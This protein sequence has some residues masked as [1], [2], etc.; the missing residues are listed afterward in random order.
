MHSERAAQDCTRVCH[1]VEGLAYGGA[2]VL[3]HELAV[4]LRDTPFA[5]LV[6][7]LQ[8]GP[9]G[10]AMARDGITIECLDLPRRAITAGPAFATFVARVVSRLRRVIDTHH[11]GLLHAHLPDPIMW[12]TVAGALEGIPVVGTHHGPA[13]LPMGR[14]ALDPRNALRR[15]LYRASARYSARTIAVSREVHDL[16]CGPFGFDPRTTVLITNG[17]DTAKYGGP[18]DG[19][20]VRRELGLEGRRVLTCIARLA[21][22]KGQAVLIDALTELRSTRPDLAVVIVG[23]GVERPAL[24]ALARARGL[25]RDVLFVGRRADIPDVLD[26]TDVF[27]LPSFGEG[28]PLALLEAMATGIPAVATAIPGN[29]DIISDPSVGVLVPPRDAAALARGLASVLDDPEFARRLGQAG[30]AHVRRHFDL[31]T[32]VEVTAG[33]Y[34]DVL[35]G[36]GGGRRAAA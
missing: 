32:M 25:E 16:L 8:N 5:P 14:G 20:R 28:I 33:V 21:P 36:R 10:E 31:A 35:A 19:A 12:A 34:N 9:V 2:E 29:T 24:E 7:C 23:F 4:R 27:V 15:L 22:I 18:R 3:V 1:V 26:A 6:C 11:V 13:L 17:I 30:Q